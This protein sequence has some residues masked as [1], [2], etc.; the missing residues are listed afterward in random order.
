MRG[1]ASLNN[2]PCPVC[3]GCQQGCFGG[4]FLGGFRGWE[5]GWSPHF[6]RALNDW[7]VEEVHTFLS[8]I[9]AKRVLPF[10]ED[11]LLMKGAKDGCFSMK[12]FYS[13]LATPRAFIFPFRLVWNPWVPTKVSF[14]AWEASWGRILTLDQLKKRGRA[15]ANRCFLCGEG[16]EIVDHLLVHCPVARAVWELLLVIFEKA[17][18]ATPL[19]IF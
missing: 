2:L 16:E 15:L 9:Q 18:M 10:Q 17:W 12:L 8:L 14:F 1:G 4:K 19:C 6:S 13:I 11:M 7:E 5:M 3:S